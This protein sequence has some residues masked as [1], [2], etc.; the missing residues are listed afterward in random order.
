M[1]SEWG[2]HSEQPQPH[3]G[4]AWQIPFRFIIYGAICLS[5]H[6]QEPLSKGKVYQAP[7]ASLCSL[8]VAPLAGKMKIRD[9]Y[10]LPRGRL[11][12]ARPPGTGPLGTNKGSMGLV[13][14]PRGCPCPR[15]SLS[16][17][18]DDSISL[19]QNQTPGPSPGWVGMISWMWSMAVCILAHF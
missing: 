15:P 2:T 3:T 7:G 13:L 1:P 10:F 8:F 9:S 16:W 19:S 18:A 4:G 14:V 12:E 17:F 11:G 5:C 6:R